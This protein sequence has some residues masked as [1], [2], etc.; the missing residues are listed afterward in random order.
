MFGVPSFVMEEFTR[1]KML[2]LGKSINQC[3]M[4]FFKESEEMTYLDSLLYNVPRWVKKTF[5]GEQKGSTGRNQ[6]EEQKIKIGIE[7]GRL[8]RK[9]RKP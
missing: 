7:G 3:P 2:S 5:S 4:E 1:T 9:R 6:I 8:R